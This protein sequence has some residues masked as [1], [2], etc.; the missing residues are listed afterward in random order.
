MASFKVQ[1]IGEA[2]VWS[3][4]FEYAFTI[5]PPWYRTWWAYGLYV[6]AI[7]GLL[8]GLRNYELRRQLAKAEIYAER[9][10]SAFISEQ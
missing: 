6:L 5:L 9:R 10:G 3:K 1:A 2:R 7:G 4:S 8:L